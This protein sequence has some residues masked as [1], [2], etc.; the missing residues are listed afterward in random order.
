MAHTLVKNFL[1]FSLALLVLGL[2]RRD[3]F[4]HPEKAHETL[5]EDPR[6][7]APSRTPFETTVGGVTYRIKPLHA[8]D[9]HGLVVSRYDTSSW[10]GDV[11]A[12][13]KDNLNVA[14]LCVV[15][16]DNIRAG[17]YRYASFWNDETWCN[18]SFTDSRGAIDPV[19]V[20]NNHLLTDDPELARALRGV[21]V[22]DQVRLRGHLA[23]YAHY[24]VTGFRRGSSVSRADTGAG[25]CETLFVEELEVLQRGGGPWRAVA[26]IAP[27]LFAVGV[28]SWFLLPARVR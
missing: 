6:Q 10:W 9:L 7:L 3:A 5:L 23:E 22:G 19:A 27:L 4:P 16:G 25:A 24:A 12:R 26:R 13:W 28:V 15:W 11:H 14:D 18:Y 2:W 20:A 1:L 17:R 21:R 8:Y